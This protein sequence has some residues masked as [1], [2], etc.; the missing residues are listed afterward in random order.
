MKNYRNELRPIKS[1][2]QVFLTESW[3]CVKVAEKMKSWKVSHVL[4]IGPGPG[5]LTTQL[6]KAGIKVTAVEKD[7]RFYD[8][9]QDLKLN[10]PEDQRENLELVHCDILRFDLDEWAKPNTHQAIV[11][12]IPYNIST[13]ILMATLKHLPK[14]KGLEFLVQLEFGQRVAASA[15]NKNYGSLSV[16]TQLR[17]KVELDGTV[18]RGCFRPAPKVDSVLLALQPLAKMHDQE[19][20]LKTEA[21]TRAAFM[22]RRKKMRNSISAF[23]KGLPESDIPVDLNRR[24]ETLTPAE[25]VALAT[26]LPTPSKS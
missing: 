24:G 23:T 21:L 10:L 20:L 8:H 11:G 22:Q 25:F 3:P 19:T 6:L 14:L 9:M 5:I 12:N 1:L 18:P 7:H 15:N 13:P 26:A 17:A 16:F 2:G 4:E